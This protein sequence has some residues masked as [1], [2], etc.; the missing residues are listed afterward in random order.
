MGR[1]C[2]LTPGY[3]GEFH[4]I[5][6]HKSNRYQQCRVQTKLETKITKIQ[7]LAMKWGVQSWDLTSLGCFEE[8]VNKN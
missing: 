6:L 2:D 8:L 1:G 5:F 4:S 3:H 7:I